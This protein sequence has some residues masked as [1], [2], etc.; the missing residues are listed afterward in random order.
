MYSYEEFLNA[1]GLVKSEM[2]KLVYDMYVEC[3][4]EDKFSACT[5]N[6]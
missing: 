2:S 1:V 6:S 4:H 3:Y 5:I